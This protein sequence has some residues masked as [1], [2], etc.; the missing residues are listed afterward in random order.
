M[1]RLQML[2]MWVSSCQDWALSSQLCYILL[3][4]ETGNWI[5]TF[6]RLDILKLNT[7]LQGL[8]L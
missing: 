3:V 2:D 1:H 6:S 4:K 5:R 8:H 7:R